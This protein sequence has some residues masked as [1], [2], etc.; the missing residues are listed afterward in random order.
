MKKFFPLIFA[1]L[2]GLTLTACDT[3]N[4]DPLV[5]EN[6]TNTPH[7]EQGNISGGD[8]NNISNDLSRDE[9]TDLRFMVEGME[10]LVPATLYIGQGY[11]IY[12][13]NEGWRLEEDINEGIQIDTWESVINDDVELSVL[14]LGERTLDQA[15]DWIITEEEDFIFTEDEQGNL[16]GTDMEDQKNIAVIF[17][18]ADNAMYAVQYTYPIEAAEGFGT[19]LSVIASTFE[20]SN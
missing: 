14:H 5:D 4:D 12:V 1:L 16:V 2:V 17:Y 7:Q 13:P 15:Q 9:T 6:T 18:S 8:Q 19:R 3:Q 20:I 11:S 10:E